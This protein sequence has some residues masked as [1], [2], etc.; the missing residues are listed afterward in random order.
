MSTDA[1]HL[2]RFL[3]RV[4]H[5]AMLWHIGETVGQGVGVAAI[6]GGLL[7]AW[8]MWVGRDATL[9]VVAVFALGAVAGLAR[10]VATLPSRLAAAA[11]VDRQLNLRDLLSSALAVGD[12]TEHWARVV[13]A[14]ANERARALRLNDVV[15]RRLDARTWGG[16]GVASAMAVILTMLAHQPAGAVATGTANNRARTALAERPAEVPRWQ[17]EADKRSAPPHVAA[18]SADKSNPA[19]GAAARSTATRGPTVAADASSK[20]PDGGPVGAQTSDR[21]ADA[22]ATIARAASTD[23]RGERP[24]T[25]DGR[26]TRA[27]AGTGDAAGR[28]TGDPDRNE[29]AAVNESLSSRAARGMAGGPSVRLESVPDQYRDVLRAYFGSSE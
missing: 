13:V 27:T 7:A 29:A 11:A 14:Q 25:G 19:E 28:V 4:H 26:A 16:I 8:A 3:R 1:P 17:A 12:S 21:A 9:P 2:D 24:A 6:A 10:G 20:S 22:L 5:R 15:L 18:T 23:E